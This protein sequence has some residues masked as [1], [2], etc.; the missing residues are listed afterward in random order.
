MAKNSH[1]VVLIVEDIAKRLVI[2]DFGH[3]LLALSRGD[4]QNGVFSALLID[5]KELKSDSHLDVDDL[6]LCKDI[7]LLMKG[8]LSRDLLYV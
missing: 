8:T 4:I 1:Q 5:F 6:H 3:G 7:A 2:G